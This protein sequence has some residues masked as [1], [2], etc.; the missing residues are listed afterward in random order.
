[1]IPDR[2]KFH[3]ALLIITLIGMLIYG[4]VSGSITCVRRKTMTAEDY[5]RQAEELLDRKD[6]P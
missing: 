4:A 6:R 3:G 1:M 5:D 2:W